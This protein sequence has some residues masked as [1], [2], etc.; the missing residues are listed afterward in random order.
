MVAILVFVN[1][2]SKNSFLLFHHQSNFIFNIFSFLIL[3]F[4]V[5]LV[6]IFFSSLKFFHVV[7]I[8]MV[9]TKKIPIMSTIFLHV[10]LLLD[11]KLS[12]CCCT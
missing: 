5:H 11:S 10:L 3:G 7:L 6:F 8:Y 9:T 1:L 4:C 12:I 2:H